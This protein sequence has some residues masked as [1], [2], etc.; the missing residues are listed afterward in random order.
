MLYRYT[1]I[2]AGHWK[3][4]D[5]VII[6][7]RPEGSQIVRFTPIT[8]TDTPHFMEQLIALYNDYLG[9]NSYEPLILI[10]LFVFD[11]LC[12]HPFS[13]GNGRIGRLLTLLLLYQA[14]F[15]VGKYISFERVIEDSKATYYEA[16][17]LSSKDWQEG[18]HN[19]FPWLSYFYGMLIAAY[20]EFESRVGVFK[21]KGSK[22]DQVRA[23][24]E[25]FPG[26][27]SINDI[28]RA[29]PNVSRDMIRKIL[30]EL[31]DQGI[32]SP[33]SMGRGAQWIK[34]SR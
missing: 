28:E 21:G 12:I 31:R 4:S 9:K 6:E 29:C 24:I 13:D 5:N 32:I 16:L 7:K 14:G 25:Q 10:P 2:E 1:S 27:F 8:W 23:A 34:K 26:P 11:F 19:I 33:T 22:T 30:R 17:G 3:K 15:K 20:K 18:K